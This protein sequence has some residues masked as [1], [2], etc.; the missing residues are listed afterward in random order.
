MHVSNSQLPD[1]FAAYITGQDPKNMLI[2]MSR[3]LGGSALQGRQ[4]LVRV[5]ELTDENRL[6][7][8]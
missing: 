6:N 3:N 7:Q 4:I 8:Y 5:D 1:R 2:L